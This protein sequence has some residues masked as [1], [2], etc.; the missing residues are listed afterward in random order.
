MTADDRRT[1]AAINVCVYFRGG[2]AETLVQI[3]DIP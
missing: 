3:E 2:V 1:F